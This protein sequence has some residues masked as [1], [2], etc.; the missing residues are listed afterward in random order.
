MP[1]LLLRNL[2]LKTF[3]LLE[4]RAKQTGHSLQSEAKLILSQSTNRNLA[5]SLS[6]ASKWRAK[7]GK[8][9]TDSAV[10]LQEDRG[11]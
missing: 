8:R 4:Q 1:D 3:H 7:L 6:R 9:D 2:N 5:D 10:F 11:R